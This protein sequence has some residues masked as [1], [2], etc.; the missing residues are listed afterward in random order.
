MKTPTQIPQLLILIFLFFPLPYSFTQIKGW[1]EQPVIWLRADQIGD[2]PKI[3]AD[4]SGNEKN[5]ESH[6]PLLLTN[7]IN[8]NP[9]VD[10]SEFEDS[11]LAS[12]NE[13]SGDYLQIFTVFKN[14][15]DN[16]NEELI[17]SFL[18]NESSILQLSNQKLYDKQKVYT[19]KGGK[20]NVPALS[21][22]EKFQPE[23]NSWDNQKIYLAGSAPFYDKPASFSGLLAEVIVFYQE[24]SPI[25]YHGISTYLAIKY[26]I[27]IFESD[28]YDPWGN[29][30]WKKNESKDYLHNIFG[31]GCNTTFALNQK[32]ATSSSSNLLSISI[33]NF[34]EGQQSN[35]AE[36]ANGSYILFSDNA[37]NCRE[38][39]SVAQKE[40]GSLLL[41]KLRWKISRSGPKIPSGSL[42]LKLKA[43][44]FF[45]KQY[46]NI[47]LIIDNSKD[48]SF[49]NVM[50]YPAEKVENGTAFFK[51][52]N[53]GSSS[54]SSDYFT[55]GIHSPLSL[56][57]NYKAPACSGTMGELEFN[58]KGGEAPYLCT[59]INHKNDTL[60]NDKKIPPLSKIDSIP[61]GIYRLMISDNLNNQY[62]LETGSNLRVKQPKLGLKTIY[63]YTDQPIELNI[64]SLASDWSGEIEWIKD[65]F[66]I[67]NSCA[68]TLSEIGGYQ[69]KLTT[70]QGCELSQYF[71]ITNKLSGDLT[72]MPEE[73]EQE[74][75][76][77][78]LMPNPTTEIFELHFNFNQEQNICIYITDTK[79]GQ[80]NRI[81]LK[82]IQHQVYKSTLEYPGLYLVTVISNNEVL[83]NQRLIVK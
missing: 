75:P 19:Y 68:V 17:W 36:L 5:A 66:T 23:N 13:D 65:N 15:E 12:I 14:T 47:N 27:H 71:H 69:L 51:N 20:L 33:G 26:G 18:A 28:Y 1:T 38:Y 10:F 74:E 77:I 82:N 40:N 57:A 4:V 58:I 78:R 29:T 67:S 53:W 30:I 46:E 72:T 34:H 55:F 21:I 80:T 76:G 25:Q 54:T 16:N 70:S 45:A 48:G 83:L 6:S 22:V 60:L 37:G 35:S 31:I 2:N 41:S 50:A 7:G 61:E 11:L 73:T 43:D 44:T 62:V 63:T 9:C 64:C 59:L 8:F 56:T 79:G 3:W 42:Y 52:I 49:D 32:Q 24:L 81:E 39:S